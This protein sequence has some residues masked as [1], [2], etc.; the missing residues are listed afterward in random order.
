MPERTFV[1]TSGWVALFVK[2]DKFH[3]HA[4]E[5]F[6]SIQDADTV[7]YTSDYVIDETVTTIRMSSNHRQS[8]IALEAIMD[9]QMTSIVYVN[10]DYFLKTTQLY[11]KYKDQPYSFT[12]I[13]SFVVCHDLRVKNV[14]SF[15]SHFRIA[16]FNLL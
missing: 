3:G 1:D 11:Q 10:P 12:D 7:L 15:D 13:S 6:K 9:S 5:V 16:G 4:K 8:L 2:N 14:F